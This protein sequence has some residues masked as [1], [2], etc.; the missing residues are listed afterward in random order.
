M[1][2][3]KEFLLTYFLFACLFVIIIARLDY[4]AV[5]EVLIF[6]QFSSAVQCI[7]V[8]ITG[9]S[10]FEADETFN[11]NVASSNPQVNVSTPIISITIV[12]DDGR[13]VCISSVTHY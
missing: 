12:N 8:V 1:I 10:V 3:T 9:D 4:Q 13:C 11:L 6:S 7:S 5:S 2:T